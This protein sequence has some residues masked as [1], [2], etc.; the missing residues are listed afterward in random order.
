MVFVCWLAFAGLHRRTVMTRSNDGLIHV[1][2]YG[3]VRVLDDRK[4]IEFATV[5]LQG[6]ERLFTWAALRWFG[7]SSSKLFFL[8][9]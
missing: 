4:S 5:I 9:G 8:L 7:A 6:V 3:E 1:D 2:F